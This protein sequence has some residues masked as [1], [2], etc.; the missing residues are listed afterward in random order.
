MALPQLNTEG[1][2]VSNTLAKIS[3]MK[4]NELLNQNIQNEIESRNAMQEIAARNAARLEEKQ[5]LEIKKAKEE[6]FVQ[7]TL[8]VENHPDP[9]SAYEELRKVYPQAPDASHFIQTDAEGRR[10]W[11]KDLYNSFASGARDA[12][13]LQNHPKEGDDVFPVIANPGYKKELAV[14][15]V[16][17]PMIK[18]RLVSRNGKLVQ[19]KEYPIEPVVDTIAKDVENTKHQRKMEIIAG[20]RAANQD[21]RESRIASDAKDNWRTIATSEDGKRSL[22][23]NKEG[24]Q[25]WI[26]VPKTAEGEVPKVVGKPAAKKEPTIAEKMMAESKKKKLAKKL[27]DDGT[28]MRV[29]VKEGKPLMGTKDGKNW[30]EVK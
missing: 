27:I 23:E 17:S 24:N 19:D 8:Y 22:Q 13:T 15:S 16:N 5:G 1:I 6:D 10:V 28:Y 25:R 30:E 4:H 2:D 26:D 11:N 3:S 29:L 7:G 9:I 12:I 14:S 20:Q 18:V 21:R